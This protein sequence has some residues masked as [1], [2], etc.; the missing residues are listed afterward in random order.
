MLASDNSQKQY[1]YLWWAKP[2]RPI[3]RRYSG[4]DNTHDYFTLE[5][6]GKHKDPL[7]NFNLED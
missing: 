4:E 6:V 5:N 2:K 3:R 1:V 7:S